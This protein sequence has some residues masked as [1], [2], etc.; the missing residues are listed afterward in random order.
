MTI[1]YFYRELYELVLAKA[2]FSVQKLRDYFSD[3]NLILL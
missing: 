2:C 1:L 3:D